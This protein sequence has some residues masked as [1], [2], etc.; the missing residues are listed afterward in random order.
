[1]KIAKTTHPLLTAATRRLPDTIALIRR[2]V[3]H[4]SPSFN[5]DAV[6]GLGRKLADE[7]RQRGATVK[8]HP[9]KKFGDH[10][11]AD[12]PGAQSPKPGARSPKPILLLGHFDTVYEMGT[13]ASMPWRE[14]GGRLQ[15][16][17]VLDMKT[18]IAQMLAAI[19][20]LR[21][22]R[23]ALPRPVRVLLVT[24][25][26]V[27][28]ESSRAVIER[29]AK[30]SAAVLVCEASYG[31]QGHL[32]TARKGVGNFTVRVTGVSAHAGLDPEK[33]QSAIVELAHQ[34][35]RIAAFSD[36]KRG[37]TVNPGVIRGGTRTNVV[38]ENA[39]CEIDVRIS[40]R[41]DEAVIDK[42]FRS[43]KPVNWRCRLEVTG[44]I[45]RPPMERTKEIA[46]LFAKARQIGAELGMKFGE[47]SVGGGSDGNLTAALGVPTLDG[48]GAVGDGAHARHEYVVIDEI[49]KRVALLARLIETI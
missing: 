11:Q 28:S 46:A 38:A 22:T 8:V 20:L 18:G 32:K 45:N 16:P 14:S 23:G 7:L 37:L 49:P 6:D 43:L 26:E 2:M 33:G 12:W 19:D 47:V 48:L 10:L 36:P 13:L 35:T 5:K 30:Q 39:E 25:E 40:K 31:P 1:M 27:G 21:E 4:E 3:E 15:G 41:A 24:D 44:G 17:G 34:I 29:L 9:A 42:K